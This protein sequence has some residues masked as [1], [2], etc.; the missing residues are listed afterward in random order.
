MSLLPDGKTADPAMW[1]D[2]LK[3][4]EKSKAGE[5]GTDLGLH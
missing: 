3:A 5:A 1:K 4:V 2:W